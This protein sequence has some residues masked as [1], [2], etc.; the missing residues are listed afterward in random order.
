MPG[1]PRTPRT[2]GSADEPRRGRG[3]P[4]D[5]DSAD[6]RQRIVECA[7]DKFASEGFE[8]TT[9]RAIATAAGVS[10]TA[11]YHYFPSKA[12]LYVAVCESIDASLVEAIRS[13]ISHHATLERRLSALFGEVGRLASESPST[14]TFVA[15]MS[16]VVRKHPEVVVGAERLRTDFRKVVLT[17]VQTS[18]ER[19][20][21]LRGASDVAFADLV[22]S[23]LA[24]LGRLNAK[25]DR[26]RHVAAGDAFLRLVRVPGT[27]GRRR[28]NSK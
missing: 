25:G 12:D 23:V 14:I 5:T 13:A 11:L 2:A 17:L 10:T 19:D 24:G 4:A 16:A 26:Q 15:G 9:N 6:T 20:D 18:E 8:A 27:S 21:I 3:R 1:A 22:T 28:G 7:R